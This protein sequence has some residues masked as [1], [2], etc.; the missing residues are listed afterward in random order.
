VT[1]ELPPAD[2]PTTSERGY[3]FAIE[4]TLTA[5]LDEVLGEAPVYQLSMPD[6]N[7]ADA[8]SIAA[9][10]EISGGVEAGTEDTFSAN[11]NGELFIAPMLVQYFS[12]ATA[13]PG[14][15]PND[16]EAVAFAREWLRL[17]EMAPSDL[18]EGKVEPRPDQPEQV[19]VLFQPRSPRPLLA[20]YPAITVALGT[21]GTI[22]EATF[23][24]ATVSAPD[25]YQLRPA[26]DAWRQVESGQAYIEIELDSDLFPSESVVQGTAEY[27]DISLAYTT[28]GTPGEEQFLQPVFV[29]EGEFTPQGDVSLTPISAYVPALVNSQTPLGAATLHGRA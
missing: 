8:V 10:L 28:S 12:P 9:R 7:M 4:A 20:G 3:T 24:W 13:R 22:L 17:T 27:T 15:L 25:L 11:G 18:G 16:E 1:A 6:L 23:R 19:V 26:E 2:L 5:N 21:N 29:F 14:E